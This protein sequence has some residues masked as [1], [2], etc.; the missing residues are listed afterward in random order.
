MKNI[1]DWNFWKIKDEYVCPTKENGWKGFPP[2]PEKDQ[3][4]NLDKLVFWAD[5]QVII[6]VVFILALPLGF[7][8]AWL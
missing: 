3:M 6:T 4:T 5:P 7:L 2:L 8:I 1:K